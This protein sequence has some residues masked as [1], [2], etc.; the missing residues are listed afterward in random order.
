MI[1][2]RSFLKG[3]LTVAAASFVPVHSSALP[4]LYGDGVHDDAPALNA[5]F[6]N[7]PYHC[8]NVNIVQNTGTHTI[9]ENGR[10]LLGSTVKVV[11]KPGHRTVITKNL[12]F[13]SSKKFDGDCLFFFDYFDYSMGM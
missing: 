11:C 12:E 7:R 3:V 6:N 5:L 13:L 9:L 10:F 1:H 2:R 8:S 4:I